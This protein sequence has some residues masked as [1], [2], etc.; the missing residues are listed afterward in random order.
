M[1]TRGDVGRRCSLVIISINLL[2]IPL[3]DLEL[4]RA[5]SRA[6]Q[7]EL[8]RARAVIARL[9]DTGVAA[10]VSPSALADTGVV[11]ALDPTAL[12]AV[13]ELRPQTKV[14][15]V[16]QSIGCAPALALAAEHGLPVILI[17]PSTSLAAMASTLLP[18]LPL[19][20]LRLLVKDKFDNYALAPRVTAPALVLHGTRD[21]I[22]PFRDGTGARRCPCRRDLCPPRIRG[23]QRHAKPAARQSRLRRH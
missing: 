4:E 15:L 11:V 13:G 14:K 22:V 7:L 16:G 9:G 17:S 20:A 12:R 8:D 3:R 19:R 1:G 5:R 21:E 2:R 18:F 6:L 10:A 23:P